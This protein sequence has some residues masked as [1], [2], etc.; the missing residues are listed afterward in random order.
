QDAA[1][2][3]RWIRRAA[4]RGLPEAENRLG[5]CYLTGEGVEI[6]REEGLA[7]LQ[8]AADHGSR[9]ARESLDKIK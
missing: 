1:E 3:V 9:A 8:K 5:V 4:D 2:G 7:W 6:N